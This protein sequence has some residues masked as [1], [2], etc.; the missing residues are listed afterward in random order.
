MRQVLSVVAVW[1]VVWWSGSAVAAQPTPRGREFQVNTYT[2]NDQYQTATAMDDDGDFVVVWTSDEQDGSSHGVFAQRFASSG[3][4]RGA[5]FQVNTRTGLFQYRPSA[6]M[7][8]DGDFVV[9]WSSFGD[10]GNVGVFAQRF[11]ST[12]AK[13]GAEF[14]VNTYT[15]DFQSFS[16]VAMDDDGDFVVVWQDY[17]DG[18]ARASSLNASTRPD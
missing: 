14:Q 3:L 16:S 15:P 1:L 17:H 5:E 4:R 13:L 6:A 11:A 7:D 8:S 2:R 18:S 9:A 12:G 10:G